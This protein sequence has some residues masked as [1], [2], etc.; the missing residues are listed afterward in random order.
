[1]APAVGARIGR[2]AA[3]AEARGAE[4][5]LGA[6]DALAPDTVTTY[7]PYWALRAHLLNALGRLAEAREAY[8][9]ATGLSEDPAVREFL[10]AR[11]PA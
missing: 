1:M 7:Q 9:K 4:A 2:A 10:A 3:L 11:T 5:G 8:T 6:L